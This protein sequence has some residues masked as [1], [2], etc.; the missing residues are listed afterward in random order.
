MTH[1]FGTG[2]ADEVLLGSLGN[3]T[4]EAISLGPRSTFVSRPK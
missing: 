4:I 1:V 3:V 2:T